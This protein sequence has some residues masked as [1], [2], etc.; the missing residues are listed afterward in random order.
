MNMPNT[1]F[2]I[3]ILH[4]L[5][6]N[7]IICNFERNVFI[8]SVLNGMH[9]HNVKYTFMSHLKVSHFSYVC[10]LPS[11]TFSKM[12]CKLSKLSLLF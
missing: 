1:P 4:L 5:Y 2:V 6:T 10:I 8:Y 12:L 9:D 7:T 3:Q 11:L